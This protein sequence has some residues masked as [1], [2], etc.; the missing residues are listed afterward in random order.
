MISKTIYI[1]VGIL[2]LLHWTF[3]Y[4][5][6][7][8]DIEAQYKRAIHAAA[9]EIYKVRG[10]PNQHVAILSDNSSLYIPHALYL[11]SKEGTLSSNKLVPRSN[12]KSKKLAQSN[13]TAN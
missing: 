12:M 9:M 11:I 7:Y 10:R 2:V 8:P 5:L 3:A 1:A 6:H 13:I 4:K